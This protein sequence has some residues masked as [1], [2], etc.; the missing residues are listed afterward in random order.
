L[1]RKLATPFLLA[2]CCALL[3][4]CGPGDR[5][6]SAAQG[7]GESEAPLPKPEAGDGSITG[8]PDRP[9][10]GPVGE[11]VA[12]AGTDP[13]AD[14]D[15]GLAPGD[16]VVL[17]P[18]DDTL[19]A[20][21]ADTTQA[22]PPQLPAEPTPADAVAVIDAYYAAIAAN[23]YPRAYALWSGGGQASGQTAQQFAAGFADTASV[24]V[25]VGA[26][27]R[28]DAAAGS[29]YIEVPVAVTATRRD[30]SL[31]RYAGAYTLRR[32]VVDGATDEQRAW[33]LASADLREV[34]P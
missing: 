6:A 21:P 1:D 20:P 11:S 34:Q 14:A 12:D 13:G 10:P 3:A 24:S 29:R 28:V 5:A 26:P 7:G 33:R 15:A 2:A 19:P 16:A 31:H 9:G 22:S 8:M 25:V 4:A 30:G 32:A 27:G 17:P 18:G 23:Q